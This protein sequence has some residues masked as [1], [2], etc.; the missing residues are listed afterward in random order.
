MESWQVLG[1]C[2][3]GSLTV[4]SKATVPGWPIVVVSRNPAYRAAQDDEAHEAHLAEG[5]FQKVASIVEDL[6]FK[7]RP[8]LD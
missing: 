8:K 5:R 2:R 7:A 1:L 3:T 4:V 6:A